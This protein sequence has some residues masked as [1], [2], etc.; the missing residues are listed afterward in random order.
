MGLSPVFICNLTL[1]TVVQC[2]PFLPLPVRMSGSGLQVVF[3]LSRTHFLSTSRINFFLY[4]STVFGWGGVPDGGRLLR[5]V[6]KVCSEGFKQ[7]QDAQNRAQ[8]TYSESIDLLFGQ[9]RSFLGWPQSTSLR[10]CPKVVTV[11]KPFFRIYREQ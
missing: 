1:K 7:G 10:V 3:L 9:I 6:A 11:P 5:Q 2:S 8:S 4:M